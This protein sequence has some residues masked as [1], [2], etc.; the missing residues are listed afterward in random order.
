[1]AKGKGQFKSGKQKTGGRKKGSKNKI[2]GLLR[3]TLTTI[4]EDYY[5]GKFASDLIRLTPATRSFLMKDLAEYVL[6]KLQRVEQFQGDGKGNPV[7]RK[8]IKFSDGTII[9]L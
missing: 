2:S 4:V 9:E 8:Q 6:P 1:M 5:S 7:P 3:E